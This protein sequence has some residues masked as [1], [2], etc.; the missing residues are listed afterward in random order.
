[1]KVIK[2]IAALG[3]VA[4]LS[5]C[6]TRLMDFTI[7]STKNVDLSR[8]GSFKRNSTRVTGEDKKRIIVIIPT[9]V[10]SAK[11]AVDRAIES[12]PGGVALVDGVLTQEFFYIPYIYGEQKFVVEGT[13]LIDPAL[14]S[15][16]NLG[17]T[18]QSNSVVFCDENGKVISTEDYTDEDFASLINSI[19]SPN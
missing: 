10:P 15:R 7:I 19:K 12:V 8:A 18:D 6:T 2:F 9:G 16:V 5:S 14:R 11:E 4:A 3:I 13:V 1:M 17:M